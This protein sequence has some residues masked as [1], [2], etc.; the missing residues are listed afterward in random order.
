MGYRIGVDIGG[1]FT[2]LCMLDDASGSLSYLKVHSTPHDPAAAVIAGVEQLLGQ[3][4]VMAGQVDYFAHGTTVATNTLI[5]HRGAKTALIATRGFK[6]LLELARQ[7]RPDLYDLQ[8]EKTPALVPRQY[9]EEV[10]ERVAYNGEVLS[11]LDET[12]V[13]RAVSGVVANGVEAIAVCLLHS[14]AN[15]KHEQRIQAMLAERFPNVHVS[16]SHE[17]L[18]EF[19]E[20]ERTSTTVVN[21]YIAPSTGGYL[22][23]LETGLERMGMRVG[24]HISSSNG[25][26]MSVSSAAKRPAAIIASGPAAGVAG[27]TYI[28][29]LAGWRD[30]LTMDIGGTSVDVSLIRDGVAHMATQTQVAGLPVRLPMIDVHSV[31]A[32]G[33]SIAW[34][35]NGLLKVGP[36]SAG[37]DPGPASYGLGGEHPTV[38]DAQLILRRLSPEYPLAGRLNLNADLAADAIEREIARPLGLGLNEAARGIVAVL[39]ANLVRALRRISVE[40]GDDPREFVLVAFGGAGPLHGA[41]VAC[42]LGVNEVLIP[43]HP[44][45]LCAIGLLAADIRSD[46]S[47]TY[48]L[49]TLTATP[50]EVLSVFADLDENA[51]RWL[52]REGIAPEDRMLQ[53]AIDMRYVGQNHELT[54]GLVDGRIDASILRELHSRF[55]RIHETAYGHSAKDENTQMV[56]FRVT[57]IGTV[58]KVQ[59][60][61]LARRQPAAVTPVSPGTSRMVFFEERGAF[62]P[63]AVVMRDTLRPGH[64]IEGPAVIEQMDSTVVIPPGMVGTVDP[65]INLIIEVHPKRE[66]KNAS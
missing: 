13:S 9:C 10:S 34:I 21:A 24:P 66:A 2:D 38:T 44:G 57:A 6:D 49:Q 8:T 56:T 26:V 17:V 30:L 51:N 55:H 42:E 27:A 65:N 53:R 47:R 43:E 54:V 7:K 58:P 11:P 48:I 22:N 39:E 36:Q 15:P 45:L 23:R 1:T 33:G 29:T 18:R 64:R 32:G 12:D 52:E 60:G 3:A 46:F 25:G 62:V 19:R 5:Q 20:Y 14:Y 16:V 61:D 63:T 31:G 4:G 40:R 37:A 41:S 28:C 50:A 59:L 35:D